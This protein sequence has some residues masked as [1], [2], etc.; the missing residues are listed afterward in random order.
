MLFEKLPSRLEMAQWFREWMLFQ[1]TWTPLPA[2]TWWL[3]TICNFISSLRLSLGTR[4]TC[5]QK[6]TCVYKITKAKNH[7]LQLYQI[8]L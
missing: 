8:L 5:S 3:T 7:P 2:S 6:E 4:H 1:K